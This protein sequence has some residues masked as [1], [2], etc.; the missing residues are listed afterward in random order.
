MKLKIK[1]EKSRDKC[2]LK[3]LISQEEI[4]IQLCLLNFLLK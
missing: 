3:Y 2:K 1:L 4:F